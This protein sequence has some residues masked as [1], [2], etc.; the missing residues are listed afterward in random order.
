MA[1]EKLLRLTWFKD[2]ADRRTG[3]GGQRGATR[4]ETTVHW[5]TRQGEMDGSAKCNQVRAKQ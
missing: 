4:G 2:A 5:T 3:A 1:K